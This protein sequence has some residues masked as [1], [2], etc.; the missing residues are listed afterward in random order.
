MT[1][2]HLLIVQKR[3]SK[4]ILLFVDAVKPLTLILHSTTDPAL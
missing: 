1:Q 4:L 3:I 2:N